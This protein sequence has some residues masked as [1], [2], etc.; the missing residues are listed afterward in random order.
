[1]KLNEDMQ[2]IDLT[3]VD[4]NERFKKFES[5]QEKMLEKL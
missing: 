2:S 3:V 4:L 5:D 1:M